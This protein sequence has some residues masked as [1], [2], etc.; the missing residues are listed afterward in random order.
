MS[1]CMAEAFSKFK[2]SLEADHS[3]V[4]LT[5]KVL[6]NIVAIVIYAYILQ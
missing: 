5:K 4:S 3:E 2:Y 6:T 1:T